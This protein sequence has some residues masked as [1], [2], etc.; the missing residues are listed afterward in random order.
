MEYKS[1]T[2]SELGKAFAPPDAAN[3]NQSIA[4]DHQVT[5]A[6]AAAA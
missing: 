4:I 1:R 2:L 3:L 5:L 6:G